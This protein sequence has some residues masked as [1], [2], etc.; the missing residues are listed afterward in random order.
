M[1]SIFLVDDE[2]LGLGM[3][4]DYI[5]WEEMGIYIIGTA[6]NGREALEKIEA[7]QPDIVLTDVQMPIMN[8]I[9]LA[10]KI[11]EL[12]DSIQVMF[13]TGHDEF[14]YVKSAL[15]VGAVGYLLKPL[16]LNEIES[17]ISKVKQRCEEV[18]IKKRS[19]EAAKATI[20]KELS[21]EKDM[22]RAA[23]LASDYSRLTRLPVTS[24]Y[25]LALFSIDPIEAEEEQHSLEECT[26]RLVSYL[27]YYFQAK[28]L[29]ATFVDY[30]EGETGLFME[31]DQQPGYYAWEDLAVAMR[32]ALDFTVTAAV[33][34]EAAE[35]SNLHGLYEQMRVILNERFYE[36]TGTMIHAEAVTNQLYSEHMPPFEKK[37]WFEAIHQLDFEWAAQKLHQYI[38]ALAA[39]R[40]KKKMICDWSIDL[41]DEL[42][43]QV[44]EPFS[45]GVQRAELYHSIYNASTLHEIEGLILDAAGHAVNLLGERFMDKNEKLIHK[46]R[47]LIDQNY[48]HPVTI[49][50]LSEQV[51]LSPN[52]LRSIFKEKTGMTIHDYLT[53]IR[54]GKAREMLAD[55]SLKIHD[56]A[57]RVG[58]ESTS[59]FISLFLKNEGVTPNEYR[60]TI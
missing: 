5:R 49:N 40:I 8:G 24:R 9:D 35:L 25:A 39:M 27:N 33:G 57:Q 11:H 36:G 26:T 18:A 59:Y 42:L 51:Y 19:T 31:A 54:L 28:N 2:E 29:K 48:N 1:Y 58:Y 21:Y 46:V 60:K 56:I 7:L 55:G 45:K 44:Q 34:A 38:E 6:S 17:V 10:R 43:E 13:L 37:E 22:T 52:Y 41:V 20:L 12:Y 15:H 3:M 53:R 14:H 30:K 32:S 4:R 23:E 47:T 16:D 50:S